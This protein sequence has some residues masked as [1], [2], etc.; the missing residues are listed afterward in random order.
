MSDIR[1]YIHLIVE[2]DAGGNPAWGPGGD[3]VPGMIGPY[4]MTFG[5]GKDLLD[6]FVTPFTDAFKTALSKSKEV[7]RKGGTLIWNG[8][9]TALSTLIPVYGYRYKKIFE[10]EQAAIEKIRNENK[11][12][13]SR[14]NDSF[15]GDGA[16]LAFM[17]NPGLAIAAISAH[18][19][20]KVAKEV[21]SI[22]TG[23]ESDDILKKYF[24]VKENKQVNENL[25]G[26]FVREFNATPAAKKIQNVA[27]TLY[28]KSLKQVY[29]E[30]SKVNRSNSL[31]DVA[32]NAGKQIDIKTDNQRA[33][34]I[35]LSQVKKATQDFYVKN[36]EAMVKSA[37]EGGADQNSDYIIDVK[38]VIEKIKSE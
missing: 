28:E 30:F 32:R 9:Q 1:S 8:V 14:I 21:A 26:D 16:V 18:K 34:N 25:G 29:N 36:L 20:P 27:K 23:G 3:W 38:K 12:V 24:G 33:N 35:V 2:D 10:N 11:E 4:G 15:K 17:S 6:T 19:S 31:E 22:L 13:M 37:E 7:T 5:S